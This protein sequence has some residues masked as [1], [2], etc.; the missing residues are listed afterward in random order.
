M[1][2][3]GYIINGQRFH[4]KEAEKSTQNS[5]VSI[6]AATLCRSSVK[7]NAQVVDVTQ[8]DKDAFILASQAKQVFYSRET[9]SSNWYVVLKAPP[10]RFYDLEMYEET[11]DTSSR[12]Q[13]VSAL[14][15][16]DDSDDERITNIRGDCNDKEEVDIGCAIDGDEDFVLSDGEERL[17]SNSDSDDSSGS[18]T[19]KKAKRNVAS[20]IRVV[21]W[22]ERHRDKNG[23]PKNRSVA[24]KI[25]DRE[26]IEWNGQNST[27]LKEDVSKVLGA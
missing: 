15:M 12:P 27:N 23:K 19:N 22:A 1:S 2:Y 20:I 26:K 16:N 10:K 7:D 4:T 8:Y 13:D 18:K 6:D 9:K 3:T 5:G 14:G 25:E 17:S 24:Q 11:V 21:V